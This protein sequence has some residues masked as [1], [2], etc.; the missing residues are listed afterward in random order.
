V[1]ICRLVHHRRLHRRL[2]SLST[3]GILGG[4]SSGGAMT[5]PNILD[6]FREYLTRFEA[7]AGPREFGEFVKIQG[8]LVKKLTYDEFAPRWEEF[9]RLR[10]HYEETFQ[11]GDTLNDTVMRVLR[12]RAAELVVEP[13]L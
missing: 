6:D 8:R 13:P 2:T 10:T 3:A 11:R 1:T 7:A 4:L 9:V 5:G 12:E